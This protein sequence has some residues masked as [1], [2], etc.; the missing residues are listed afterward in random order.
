MVGRRQPSGPTGCTEHQCIN[1]INTTITLIMDSR[2]VKNSGGKIAP[3]SNLRVGAAPQ[4]AFS[5]FQ[6]ADKVAA[7]DAAPDIT[8][9]SI[10]IEGFSA[11]KGDIISEYCR[12]TKC[13]VLCM[14]ETHRGKTM[15]RPDV[16]GMRIA[17]E[18]PHD[19]HGSV[20]FVRTGMDVVSVASTNKD[21]I[22]ILT[23]ELAG[24]TVSSVYKPPS[25]PFCF[26]RPSNFLSKPTQV[27]MGDFNSHG[28]TW[29]YRETNE[30]GSRVEDWAALEGLHLI[31][32]PKLPCSFNSGRWR[33]GYNPDLVFV[34]DRLSQ[35]SVKDIGDPVPS[36]Q[37]RPV[38][39]RVHGAIRPTDVPFRRRF[40]FKRADWEGFSGGLDAGIWNIEECPENYDD[41]ITLVRSVSRKTI[42]RGCRTSYVPGLSRVAS[43]KLSSYKVMH[44]NDPFAQKT[45]D[46]GEDLLHDISGSRRESWRHMVESIDMTH[47][48]K[49][50]WAMIK[51]LNGDPT[52]PRDCTN[53]TPDQVASTLLLNGKAKDHRKISQKP[54]RRN[55]AT[56]RN[57]STKPFT[58]NELDKALREMKSG[59]ASGV[60]DLT[61]EQI[62]HFGPLARI[63]L[64][65]LFNNVLHRRRIPRQWCKARVVAILKPGKDPGDPKSYRPISL[66]CHLYKLFE[67]MLLDRIVS[68]VDEKLISQQAGFRAGKSCT[69]QILNLTQHIEDGFQRGKVTGVAFVDLTAAYDTVNHRRLL[70]KLYDVTGDYGLV[71]MTRVLL[72]NRRFQVTLQGKKSRWRVQKNGLPQGSVLA[73]ILFNIY[74]NDQPI[75]PDC[76]HFLYADDLA[77][78]AQY[79]S[80][81]EVESTLEAGL[82]RMAD[83][84]RDNQLTP[85]P[86]K[87]QIAAFHLRNREAGRELKVKWEGQP[88][89]FTTLPK[90][91]GVTLDRTL[92]FKAHVESTKRKV[93]ARNN[94][95]RK[96]SGSTWGADPSTI[97]STALALCY[98]SGEYAAPVWC[99]SPHAKQMDVPL[100]DACRL[101]TGCLKAT[102]LHKLRLLA[103]IAPPSIRRDVSADTERTRQINDPRHPMFEYQAPASR[104]KSRKSFLHSTTELKCT[105]SQER[106]NRWREQCAGGVQEVRPSVDES[107]PPGHNCRYG[108][109]RAMNRLRTGVGRCGVDMVRWGFG[110]HDMCACGVLQIRNHFRECR[111][112]P[113]QCSQEDLVNATWRAV[114]VAQYWSGRI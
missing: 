29:G 58:A 109:W 100:N 41:F 91:L 25:V 83:Y 35:L 63:W 2:G 65:G 53:V 33:K 23:V 75:L 9:M 55:I 11:V 19:K 79:D 92:T 105:P 97:R 74:T 73:P 72:S 49:R 86:S 99:R 64:L 13:D 62:K 61:T 57:E 28:V 106:I 60:D 40:N 21:G 66:L 84:Y 16:S 5:T 42:P 104:L 69:G 51:R 14:Q 112:N 71:E 34:T 12:R 10:N 31:H 110:G 54:I 102:P 78:A 30:D 22:E 46:A 52:R 6:G 26:L 47:S 76:S 89:A 32:D 85:N 15:K 67:R 27:V 44:S 50:A 96:V 3:H 88:L 113:V 87:T 90:Y 8:V 103:G 82:V 59:K 111:L 38:I 68:G 24:C 45:L 93:S 107:L 1:V 70:S 80:F 4:S 108:V 81:E 98:S 56:E 114:A 43:D 101:V 37:H 18:I 94:L 17:I 7:D 36:S 95:L 77:L 48:S 20:V 39:L